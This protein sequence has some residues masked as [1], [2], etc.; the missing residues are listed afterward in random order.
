[1]RIDG[2]SKGA[3]PVKINGKPSGKVVRMASKWTKNGETSMEE[4]EKRIHFSE[5]TSFSR[6]DQKIGSAI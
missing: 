2:K 5:E 1:M 3:Q 4:K 6:Q